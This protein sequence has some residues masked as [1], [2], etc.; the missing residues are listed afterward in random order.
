[1]IGFLVIGWVALTPSG[2]YWI[3]HFMGW[4]GVYPQRWILANYLSVLTK[5]FIWPKLSTVN[6]CFKV[7]VA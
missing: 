2:H 6:Y 5:T 4:Y 3:N 1:V 7:I